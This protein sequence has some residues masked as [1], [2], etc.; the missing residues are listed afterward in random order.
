[1]ADRHLQHLVIDAG[2][3]V[4]LDLC[5]VA[6]FNR[7]SRAGVVGGHVPGALRVAGAPRS[8]CL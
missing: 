6:R 2:R 5:D 4:L 3:E 8:A 1:M 7:W